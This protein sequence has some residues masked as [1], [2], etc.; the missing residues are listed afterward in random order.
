LLKQINLAN[1]ESIS[2]GSIRA[3]AFGCSMLESIDL[4]ENFSG[5]I[6]DEAL[7][8]LAENCPSLKY[9]NFSDCS[10]ISLAG[11][12]AIIEKC[13]TVE[14]IYISNCEALRSEWLPKIANVINHHSRSSIKMINVKHN[15]ASI[16]LED[17]T[18]FKQRCPYVLLNVDIF[19]RGL[20][21]R[22]SP[23][24]PAV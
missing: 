5:A 12:N 15:D 14:R 7:F 1:V 3:L 6:T 23:S 21:L 19:D 20:D 17:A 9:V 4:S 10:N 13:G 24:P 16:N 2:D 22:R 11:I 18:T 8:A